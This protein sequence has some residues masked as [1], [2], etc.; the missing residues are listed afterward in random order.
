MAKTYNFIF[1]Q[2]V[3]GKN[4]LVGL[5]AYGIYKQ[6]KIEFIEFYKAENDGQDPSEDAC[7]TFAMTSCAES[8][9]NQYR[10]TAESLLQQLTLTAAREEINAFEA[11]MLKQYRSE[12]SSAL[13]EGKDACLRDF[14]KEIKAHIPGWWS[15]FGASLAGAFVFAILLYI[16]FLLGSTSE[17]NTVERVSSLVSTVV[18]RTN[19][20]ATDSMTI[21][22]S[23]SPTDAR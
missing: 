2:L 21:Q 1:K 16:G 12:I 10:E 19:G 7:K 8:A 9:I 4:D 22:P 11:D 13:S 6:H 17:K 14:G 5:I 20:E 18:N 23:E 15:S 3:Q